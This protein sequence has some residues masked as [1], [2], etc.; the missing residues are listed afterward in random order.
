MNA[1]E[2]LAMLACRDRD[3]QHPCQL[4]DGSGAR[5]GAPRRGSPAR[6]LHPAQPHDA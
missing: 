3:S 4:P 6:R 2:G 1:Q 5:R